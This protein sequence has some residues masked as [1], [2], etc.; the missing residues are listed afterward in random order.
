MKLLCEEFRLLASKS[1]N[2]SAI[3]TSGEDISFGD[4]LEMS[5]LWAKKLE[6]FPDIEKGTVAF[7]L[8]KGPHSL[9]LIYALIEKEIPFCPIYPD[10]SKEEQDLLISTLNPRLFITEDE[11]TDLK[12]E[13]SD[14]PIDTAY[15]IFTSGTTGRPKGVVIQRDALMSF[16]E[17]IDNFTNVIE[18]GA[19]LYGVSDWA[20]DQSVLEWILFFK[21]KIKLYFSKNQ[22]IPALIEVIE[23]KKCEAINAVPDII[24]T[25]VKLGAGRDLNLKYAMFGGSL[26]YRSWLNDFQA[27]LPNTKV[28]CLY[29]PTEATV[30]CSGQWLNIDDDS[31]SVDIGVPFKGTQFH[32]VNDELLIS[33][34]Q[35]M[36]GYLGE[37]K[38][39]GNYSTEDSVESIDE[40]IYFKGRKSGFTKFRGFR[41]STVEIE[42]KVSEFNG[43]SNSYACIDKDN[44]LLFLETDDFNEVEFRRW[45]KDKLSSYKIPTRIIAL[46][47]F[48]LLKNNK[49]DTKTLLNDISEN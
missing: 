2:D 32:I 3:Y 28:A 5:S 6:F 46:K 45:I 27:L 38:F 14:L 36:W 21:N 31:S 17:N 25:L 43:V 29:G 12:N 7:K 15:V 34:D 48:P 24:P 9:A 22:G 4:F 33:G 47:K 40:K 37:N 49:I 18:K 30:Y 13:S 26:L 39:K 23:S 20:F 1:I 11:V 41:I 19:C 8:A 10:A 44:L 35:L 16:A 42:E